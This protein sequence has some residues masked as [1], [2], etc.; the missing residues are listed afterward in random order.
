MQVGR[1]SVEHRFVRTVGPLTHFHAEV[2]VLASTFHECDGR[3][4]CPGLLTKVC[5]YSILVLQLLFCRPIGVSY[6]KVIAQLPRIYGNVNKPH[7][8]T[9]SSDLVYLLP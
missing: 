8:R 6:I 3:S 9:T 1:S 2:I 5:C 7:P 4:L